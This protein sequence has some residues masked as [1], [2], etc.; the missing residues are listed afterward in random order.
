M[1]S[2]FHFDMIFNHVTHQ[3]FS[4]IIANGMESIATE[5]NDPALRNCKAKNHFTMFSVCLNTVSEGRTANYFSI[6]MKNMDPGGC[7]ATSLIL[8]LT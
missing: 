1:V 3:I 8:V 7:R 6:Y 2:L 5:N 4:L